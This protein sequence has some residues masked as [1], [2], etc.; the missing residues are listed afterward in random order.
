MTYKILIVDDEPA[1][2]RLLER[3]FRR[4]YEIISASSGSEA[5]ELLRQHD[6]TVII[7]DQRMPGM[8]GIEM[9]K[10]AAGM[11]QHT[12]RIILTGY[13]DASAL[14]EAINSG[15]IYKYITKPWVNEDL[16]QTIT[17]ALQHYEMNRRQHDLAMH[18]ERLSTRLKAMQHGFVRL[19][20]DA[21][22]AKDEH[23]HGH[24][25]RTSGYAVA[26]GRRMGLAAEELEQLAL[27]AF[28]HDIGQIGTPGHILLKTHALTDEERRIME[29]HSERG[30]RMLASV[31]DMNEI[32]SAVR[33]HH[34]QFDGTGYPEGLI[35]EQ[36]PLHA[37]IIFVADTY[38][39]MTSP[40]P[41]RHAFTHDEAI[42]RFREATGTRFDRRVVEAFCEL[43]PIGR[44]RRSIAVGLTGMRLLP[45]RVFY[46]MTDMPTEELLQKF[47]MTPM[48]A[49][50]VLQL[51][52]VAH[53]D[54]PTA[55]LPTAMTRLGTP[56]LR[57]IIEQHGFPSAAADQE[58]H[59]QRALR[60][61]VAA[62]LLAER[63]EIIH[64]EDAYTLGLLH[65]VGEVL[66]AHLFPDEMHALEHVEED[67][68]LQR[69]VEMF[70]FDH[71][72]V[73]QWM[74]E[75][76]GVPRSL[77]AAVQTLHDVMR[78]NSP[79]AL[80]MHVAYQI[81]NAEAAYK[82]A[83]VEALGTDRLAMLRLS[84][85]DLNRIY[86]RANALGVELIQA[87]QEV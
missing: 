80:L 46:D 6:V 38:D 85:A 28:L 51:A 73:S 75:A 48:L 33:H 76:C 66:L 37:R 70:G 81:A 31:P 53:M 18:N 84:R 87:L 35:G 17:R 10:H 11:R 78:I 36:I 72:Q 40:R 3:L 86:E 44:I 24:A 25:R 32:A 22:D 74:L 63:T 60:C 57:M 56:R 26:I 1:N 68:R 14:V 41:F 69:E 16:Q 15:V 4:Q 2:L 27:A 50:D 61:A 54:A 7:S 42:K 79:I 9:L 20:A 8:T 29:L 58:A 30:A 82:V 67:V 39:A 49:M 23:A 62:Q 47:K 19:I 77:T 12:V 52:N 21:L 59:T 45:S 83:A 65:D 13:T 71:A 5:L 64:P 55:Q 34:E 43:E